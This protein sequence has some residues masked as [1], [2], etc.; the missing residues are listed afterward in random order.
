MG[1]QEDALSRWV[2]DLDPTVP[3]PCG[4][5]DPRTGAC[6]GSGPPRGALDPS[7]GG[8]GPFPCRTLCRLGPVEGALEE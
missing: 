2:A 8:S 7:Q 5:P 4:R 1:P 6:S 3:R